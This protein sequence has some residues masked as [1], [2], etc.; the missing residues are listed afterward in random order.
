MPAA[1][2]G[3]V[4]AGHGR[5]VGIGWWP[6]ARSALAAVTFLVLLANQRRPA[7]GAR[8]SRTR[9]RPRDLSI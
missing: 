3:G 2:P 4:Q 5:G 8:P 6:S 7:A 9:K 1:Y